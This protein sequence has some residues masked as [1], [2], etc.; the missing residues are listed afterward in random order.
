MITDLLERRARER[1]EHP[2]VVTPHGEVGFAAMHDAALRCAARLAQLGVGAGDHVALL[3]G[4]S[5]AFLA[6]WFGINLRGAVAVTLNNQL[7]GDGLRY[8]LDQSEAKVLVADREWHDSRAAQLDERQ[9]ALPC[10]VIEDDASFLASLQ[11]FASAEPVRVAGSEAATIMYTSGTTGLP[12]GV[13]N[14]HESYLAVGRATAQAL[15]ITGTDRIMVFLPLF[16]TNPQMYAV[17]SALTQG[18]TLVLLPR[19]SAGTFFDDAVRFRA[20]GFTFVGTVLSILAA[21]HPGECRDHSLRFCFGGGSPNAVWEAVEQRFGV[22]VHEAYGMTETGGWTTANTATVSRFGSCGKPRADMEVRVI[23]PDE[24]PLP[25]GDKGEIVVRPRQPDVMLLGYWGQPEQ[26]LASCRNLWFHT[27]DLGSLDADGF[28]YYHGRMKELIRRNGEMISPAEIETSLRRMPAVSDCA[29][30][31]VPDAVAGD[32][33]KAVVVSA[34]PIEPQAVHAFLAQRL[35][36]FLLP[37]YIEF[38]PAIPKT[39]T[40]KIQ[41]NKLQYLDSR[42][43]DLKLQR[44]CEPS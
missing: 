6:V 32:E 13:V 26:M 25:A 41:R 33:I 10:I 9:R 27:G 12:K 17:M 36:P 11:A 7:L 14:C 31:A 3:A 21:R 30:V 23:G 42:V 24:Q 18:A 37:R 19:F 40:E 43:H 28:L 44:R 29:V 22:K 2:F 20:T 38:A 16:H 34:E 15:A 8:S 5:A 39:E 4:N 1:P 35:A